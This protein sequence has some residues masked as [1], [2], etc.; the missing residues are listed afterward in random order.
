VLDRAGYQKI[1]RSL[2]MT[3]D[4]TTPN[5]SA[6]DVVIQPH[7]SHAW[8]AGVAEVIDIPPRS[9]RIHDRLLETITMPTVFALLMEQ[10]TPIAYGLA[11]AESDTVG[12]FD[13]VGAP[14]ARRRGAATSLTTALLNWGQAQ[15]ARHAYLQVVADNEPAAALYRK[16]GFK[17]QYQSHYRIRS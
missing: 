5:V 14:T 1:D 4:L 11:V 7:M 17:E 12:L 16:L 3:I 9:R 10:Q 15:G 2:V 8:S 13:I 6:P